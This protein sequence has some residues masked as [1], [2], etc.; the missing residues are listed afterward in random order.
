MDSVQLILSE[1][2]VLYII[3]FVRYTH[4]EG[5]IDYLSLGFKL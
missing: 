1:G 2:K 3:I 4:K 5:E